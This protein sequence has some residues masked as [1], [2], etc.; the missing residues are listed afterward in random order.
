MDPEFHDDL[1]SFNTTTL[2]WIRNSYAHRNALLFHPKP[3][4]RSQHMLAYSG[5][6]F[7]IFGGI[8]QNCVDEFPGGSETAPKFCMDNDQTPLLFYGDSWVWRHDHCPDDC[9]GNGECNV[10]FCVCKQSLGSGHWGYHCGY[11]MCHNSTCAWDYGTQNEYCTH[12]HDFGFCNGSTGRCHCIEPHQHILPKFYNDEKV[13]TH[14]P[15]LA[16][17]TEAPVK[18]YSEEPNFEMDERRRKD[19]LYVKCPHQ[20][21]SGH[22]YCIPNGT[23]HCEPEYIGT[24]CEYHA[25]CPSFCAYQGVCE[26]K[27]MDNTTPW[28]ASES[29]SCKCFDPFNGTVCRT[30]EKNFAY[31][32]PLPCIMVYFVS[33]LVLLFHVY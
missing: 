23:C 1:W 4:K 16:L 8:G 12:C 31:T 2:S 27:L 26:P 9:H 18:F 3:A 10:G 17:T 21:C 14:G 13:S 22:G 7:L 33:A 5:G 30:A 6:Q 19:C 20:F 11:E 28:L 29:G 32:R 24:G 15:G 25:F